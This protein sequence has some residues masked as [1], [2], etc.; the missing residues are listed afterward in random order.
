MVGAHCDSINLANPFLPAPGADDDGSGTVTILEAF[1][2]TSALNPLNR[3][4]IHSLLGIL[5]S[6]YIPTSPLEFHFYAGEEVI[7]PLDRVYAPH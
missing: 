4:S 7:N 6:G 2:G 3:Y 5:I 1:R